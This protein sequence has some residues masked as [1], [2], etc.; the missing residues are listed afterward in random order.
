MRQL[1]FQQP[2]ARLRDVFALVVVGALFSTV[3][4][5]SFGVFSLYLGGAI[6]SEALRRTWVTWWFGDVMGDLII[7]PLLLTWGYRPRFERATLFRVI[8]ISTFIGAAGLGS[9]FLL[10]DFFGTGGVLF[11]HAY[12]IFPLLMLVAICLDQRWTVTALLIV[13]TIALW[14]T[15]TGHG[16]FR[17]DSLNLRLFQAQLFL[18]VAIVSNLVLSATVMEL[19]QKENE[20]R[21]TEKN[22]RF[23]KEATQLLSESIDYKTTLKHVAQAAVPEFSDWCLVQILKEDGTLQAVELATN[24]PEKEPLFRKLI[25]RY[26][27]DVEGPSLLSTVIKTRRSQYI[28]DGSEAI[29]RSISK[30][31]P[32]FELLRELGI[33]SLIGCPL[34]FHNRTL[35]AIAAGIVQPNRRYGPNDVGILEELARRAAI[36]IENSRLYLEAREAIYARDE[37]LSIASHELKT[38]LTSLSLQLQMFNRGIKKGIEAQGASGKERAIR[39]AFRTDWPCLPRPARSNATNFPDYSTISWI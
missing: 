22:L 23:L 4:S 14:A 32:H 24:V 6:K 27:S 17:A 29:H 5:A 1:G 26:Y 21:V 35:G 18:S 31:E 11:I 3:I 36:A 37:F 25:D 30:D 15:A 12:L 7:A 13:T 28:L 38:P 8:E 9:F 19:R 16:H 10:T 20:K 2:L 34:I 33:R 39:F